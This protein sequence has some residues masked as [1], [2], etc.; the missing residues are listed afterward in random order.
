MEPAT[1]AGMT[2][3]CL[4]DGGGEGA[5]EELAAWGGQSEGVSS[6]VVLMKD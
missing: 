1:L 3:V 6:V 5:G 2:V 4:G